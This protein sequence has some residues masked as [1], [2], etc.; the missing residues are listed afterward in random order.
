MLKV[1]EWAMIKTLRDNSVPKARIAQQL[2]IDRKTVDRALKR[3]EARAS[4]RGSR[5]SKLDP[6]KP[7]IQRRLKVYDLTAKKLFDEIEAQGYDGSYELVKRY[8]RDIRPRRA[9]EQALWNRY[10]TGQAFVRFE[11]APGEQAQVDWADFGAIE[12]RGRSRPLSC[13]IMVLGYSRMTYIEFTVSQDLATVVRCHLNAF[14]YFGGLTDTILYDN[15][16]TIV[17]SRQ[18]DHIEWN[19]QFLDFARQYGF[20]P[21]LCLPGR[22]ETKGKVERTVGYVRTSFYAGLEFDGLEDLNQRGMTWL[23]NVANVRI[24]GTTKARPIDRLAEE[25]LRPLA[26]RE[27]VVE[28]TQTRKSSKDCFIYFEGNR[29]SVPHQHSC[30]ELQ[31]KVQGEELRIYSGSEL[32]ATHEISPLK[33]QMIVREE[34]FAGLPHPAYRSSMRAVRE[35]FLE[36]FPSTEGYI[37][38]LTAAR[39]GNA[40][41]HLVAILN[42]LELYPHEVVAHAVARAQEY[43]AYAVKYVRNI[44]RTTAAMDL[45][46]PVATLS[47]TRRRSLL[48]Q[49]VA[50][51][52]LSEYALVME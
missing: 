45:I 52:P 2:G 14:R 26:G 28:L 47:V 43:K 37:E 18:G 4:S 32:I 51:R 30:R 13:F 19:P 8:V 49:Q 1:Q 34:H 16:K 15:M 27:Y 21:R 25:K 24:H 50:E 29:Y 22:K 17:L 38:G 3:D 31:I 39:Y 44:C 7:Y 12:H 46:P 35:H 33:G 40:R 6:F 36:A 23:D 48:E 41:Y 9:R 11:T 42:L 5:G 10:S 20:L